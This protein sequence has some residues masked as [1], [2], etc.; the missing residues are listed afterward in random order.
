MNDRKI[1]RYLIL[2]VLALSAFSTLAMAQYAPIYTFNSAYDACCDS[3]AN[4]LAQGTDG[5]LYGTMPTGVS[6][7]SYGTWFEYPIGGQPAIHPL[8]GGPFEP[9]SGFTL[10][11]DGN[12]YGSVI[13]GNGAYGMLIKV[14]GGVL[15]VVYKFPGGTGGSYPYAPPIQGLDGN[16]YG[17]T[18][19]GSTTGYVY[20]VLTASGTLGWIHQL[21]SGTMAPLIS[22][23]DG[24]FYGTYPHGGMTINGVAPNNNN[25]GGVFQVTPA[26]VVTGIYNISPGSSTNNGHGDGQQPWGPVMQ[27]KDGYLY[28][29][30]SGGGAFNSGVVYQLKLNGAY[31]VLHNFQTLDGTVPTGTL[32]QGSDDYFYGLTS[33]GGFEKFP[34]VAAGTLFKIDTVGAN[35]V[36]LYTFFGNSNGQGPGMTPLATPTLHTSGMFYGV[37]SRGGIGNGSTTYGAYDDGGELFQYNASQEPFVSVVSVRAAHIGDQVSLI[38]KGFLNATGVKFGNAS[39]TWAK[40]KVIIWSD[41]FMTVT[42]PSGA[43]AGPVTVTETDHVYSTPYN[44]N[45]LCSGPFCNLRRP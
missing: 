32:V 34:Y 16:L 18:Y 43:T 9:Y 31:T 45:I 12:L 21:P 22:V 36:R 30:A 17:V 33:A 37:T 1:F 39:V 25:G 24:N 2:M 28:G 15:S 19:D 29:T 27:A 20:Q 26:G 4:L 10:G 38:G 44:F 35:F 5:N 13:H 6:S 41:T 7:A 14:S 40:F 8:T 42:V 11:T 3:Y 23:S